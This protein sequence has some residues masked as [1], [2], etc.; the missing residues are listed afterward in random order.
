MYGGSSGW[1]FIILYV[2]RFLNLY[3]LRDTLYYNY[4][5][6]YTIDIIEYDNK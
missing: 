3:I 6:I 2:I 1:K 4:F 5:Y